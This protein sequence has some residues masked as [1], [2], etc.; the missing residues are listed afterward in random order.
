MF[1]ISFKSK[2]VKKVMLCGICISL[3]CCAVIVMRCAFFDGYSSAES[4]D[5]RI[6]D[7]SSVLDFVSSLGW[8]VNETPDE[9][10]EVIIPSEFDDV[11]TNYNNIQLSQNYDLSDYCGERVK[12]WTYTIN[13]YPGY[14]GEEFIKINILVF[15]GKVIGGD[16]CSVKLDGFMHGFV[17]ED[18]IE[19]QQ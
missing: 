12:K 6:D 13:N 5:S 7:S 8:D 1:V 15:D 2:L 11:Y 19:K 3:V 10:R 16:V 17:K 14:E 9:I 18:E 4:V